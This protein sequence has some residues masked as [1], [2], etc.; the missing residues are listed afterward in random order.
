M[1]FPSLCSHRHFFAP[2]SPPPPMEMLPPRKMWRDV[3]PPPSLPSLP[4]APP[5]MQVTTKMFHRHDPLN[6]DAA[7]VFSQVRSNAHG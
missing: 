5:P 1:T 4:V 3:V 2:A 6:L 7:L